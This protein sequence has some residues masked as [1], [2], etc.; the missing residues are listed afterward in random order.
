[1]RKAFYN[2]GKLS[3]LLN[4]CI[5]LFWAGAPLNAA[6][7]RGEVIF[8][9]FG[10]PGAVVTISRGE[11]RILTITD[12]RGGYSFPEVGDGVWSIRIE[13][14][15]FSTIQ[16]DVRIGPESTPAQWELKLLPVDQIPGL[17]TA[18]SAVSTSNAL[19]P[20]GGRSATGT[21][22]SSTN[23]RSPFQRIEVNSNNEVN[24]PGSPDG[25]G[26]PG[27]GA[28]GDLSADELNQRA[29]DGFLIN[30]TANNSAS[31]PNGLSRSVGNNRGFVRSPYNG[32]AGATIGSSALDARPYSLAG[33]NT[34]SP[35]Y[36]QIQGAFA[37][38]GPLRVPY[39]MRKGP[40]F[41]IGYQFARRRNIQTQ[42]G[43][44]PTLEERNG[45]LSR[46]AG[47]IFDP[48]NSQPFAGNRI[49][50]ERISRQ[51]KSLLTLIPLPNFSGSALY[52]F[53]APVEGDS[54][55]DSLFANMNRSLGSRDQVSGNYSISSSRNH[56][57]TLLGF[58]D[59]S[60]SLGSNVSLNW[61]HRFSQNFGGTSSY[62]FNRQSSQTV[63]YFQNRTNISGLAGIAGNS[64]ETVNWGPPGI[65]FYGGLMALYDAV[66]SS[67]HDQSSALTAL[68]YWNH[69]NH[70]VS[71]GGEYRRQQINL[72]SQ[73]NPRGSFTFTGSS[74]LSL[75][76]PGLIPGARNDFAGFLLGIPDAVS[77]AFGN[78]DKYFRS[79]SGNAFLADDWRVNSSFTLNVG[80][81]WEYSSP[82]T[83]LHGRL[84][85]LDI[86]PNYSA[87]T[88]VIA[89]EPVGAITGLH[90][91]DSLLHADRGALQPRIGWAWKPRP[92]S[93]L[94]VRGGYGIYYNSSPY[95]SIVMEMAQQSP[96]SKSL[97]LQNSS[98]HA[99]TLAD[100]LNAAPN[101]TSNTFAVD[102]DL[103]IGYVH[104]WQFSLQRDLP[105]AMQFTATYQGTRGKHALQEILP[106]TYPVGAVNPCPSC[107]SGFRYMSSNGSSSRDAGTLQL[108]RRLHSGFT[109]SVQY[110]FSKSMDDA[111]PGAAGASGAIFIAQNWLNPRA[112]WAFS[113]FDQR[114]SADIQFQ[115]TSG[116]GVK[117]GTLLGGW[118]GILAK[119]WT[120]SGQLHASSGM[121]LTPVYPSTVRGTGIT[122]PVRPDS[123]GADIKDAPA[124]LYLNPAAYKA[125]AAGQWGNAGRNSISGPSQF[126]FNASLKRTFRT[127]DRTSLDLNVNAA[128]V[129]NYVTYSAWNTTVGNVQFGRPTS[130]NSMRS[131]Q[132]DIRWRF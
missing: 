12:A 89:G 17:Q 104:I 102:P 40:Q 10:V 27:K 5:Y 109:A 59:A 22:A 116:M 72:L 117:G 121:P 45:D 44:T 61:L 111:A 93:S 57:S 60:R 78:A 28:F 115:Y 64:Q 66:P 82:T 107:P 81:R 74:T 106:N 95:Q 68:L 25:P 47:Q 34:Q 127:S 1:M 131:I 90:Y 2:K 46:S 98:E 63:P 84:V 129:L 113:N 105:M 58:I 14:Q 4:I 9:G 67:S 71:W 73:Q 35:A 83:E 8:N 100:G 16:L 75:S 18:P 37:F 108:R 119:E 23:T 55:Q 122:G 53:Q 123:T 99:L 94:V 96:L 88:P 85:N 29:A 50:S 19:P 87:A 118:R 62:R 36:N 120:L 43:L 77:I 42:T 101:V 31:S 79:F 130:A 26:T 39:L 69:G 97:N 51:A 110:T 6:E 52:N 132:T 56:N 76:S 80:I 114:H 125:P 124:G 91:P 49:P 54:H 13:M 38:G 65:S 112:E 15:A 41:Y 3:I 86:A 128:N 92:A 70:N 30:G 103:R 126:T 7:H 48:E 32:S 20:N 33:V 21:A 11:Q 24:G